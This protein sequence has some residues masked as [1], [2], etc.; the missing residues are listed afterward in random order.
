M[1]LMATLGQIKPM[2]VAAIF[3]DTQAEPASVYEWL[4]WLETKLAF[5]VIRV[6]A[7]DMTQHQLDI[8][9]MKKR[10]GVY[11]KSIIPAHTLLPTGK[12][13]ILGR[14][15]TSDYKVKPLVRTAKQLIK[16]HSKSNAV[17]WIGIS[18]DEVVRMKESRD[19]KITHRWPLVD[20]GMN[21]SDC[22]KWMKLNAFPTPPRSA[23]YYCP[24]HSDAEWR[25]L[26]DSEPEYFKKAVEFE[27]QLQET[28]KQTT[29][30]KSIPFLHGSCVPLDQVDFSTDIERGQGLLWG[31]ECEGMCG[32]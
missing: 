8:R 3:A 12:T 4:D 10:E 14:S 24:F 2:P 7:G 32:V 5:P 16:Q 25:R 26:K 30:L 28:K 21:R 29:N 27:K 19:K 23:C 11:T 15:C 1:A 6:T 13:G 20:A 31:N 9:I 22:L 17:Q 18:L